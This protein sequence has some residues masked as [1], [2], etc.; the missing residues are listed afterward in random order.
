MQFERQW[1][2]TSLTRLKCTGSSSNTTLSHLQFD[3]IK[4]TL[5]EMVNVIGWVDPSKH[6]IKTRY[7][8]TK[9][10]QSL[11]ILVSGGILN[12]LMMFASRKLLNAV[13]SAHRNSITMS[14]GIIFLVVEKFLT[15]LPVPQRNYSKTI[16]DFSLCGNQ[17]LYSRNCLLIEQF[18]IINIFATIYFVS[19]VRQ[20]N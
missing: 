1:N 14:D 16:N 15:L 12:F 5:E 19:S 13:Q 10:Q 7:R 8:G 6:I 2:D 9:N 18:Q 3:P 20:C 4:Q 11:V 17:V